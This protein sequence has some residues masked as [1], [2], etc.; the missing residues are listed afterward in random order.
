M[1]CMQN[2][3]EWRN[4]C[5]Q[6]EKDRRDRGETQ[7]KAW[8]C[9]GYLIIVM[10][11]VT[12]ISVSIFEGVDDKDLLRGV[13][14]PMSKLPSTVIDE[15]PFIYYENELTIWVENSASML[16]FIT[17]KKVSCPESFLRYMMDPVRLIES[18]IGDIEE[19][20]YHWFNPTLAYQ[21]VHK[22]TTTMNPEDVL[23]SNFYIDYN[24]QKPS[25]DRDQY[26]NSLISV[27]NLI[28]T[29]HLNLIITDFL[30]DERA[31]NND[32]LKNVCER[33][34]QN[35]Q[36]IEIIALDGLYGGILYDAGKADVQFAF[37]YAHRS[38][39]IEENGRLKIGSATQ[40]GP[41][42]NMHHHRARPIYFILVGRTEACKAAAE[43]IIRQYEKYC[44]LEYADDENQGQHVLFDDSEKG[45]LRK[46]K[47]IV[48]GESGV[49]GVLQSINDN[50]V[51]K[52]GVIN[53]DEYCESTIDKIDA[54]GNL[55]HKEGVD[56]Y[57]ITRHKN[58]TEQ[59]YTI[60]YVFEPFVENLE[61]QSNKFDLAAPIKVEHLVFERIEKLTGAENEI[62]L[63]GGGYRQYS[64]KPFS[65]GD[66]EIHAK[67]TKNNSRDVCVELT[68]DA[69]AI[70]DGYY[71][72]EI[73]VALERKSEDY[74]P[75]I[76]QSGFSSL[77]TGRSAAMTNYHST[78]D[79]L[80]QLLHIRKAY[81]N[82]LK[83]KV[84]VA[85]VVVELQIL[86]AY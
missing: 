29:T 84:M 24:K 64:L 28:D 4:K 55:C 6:N 72:I 51:S 77:N 59:Q 73:P 32:E 43:Q 54:K 10:L 78:S 71:R 8:C 17:N 26:G 61:K 31:L 63:L 22:V 41:R 38:D 27:L 33:I 67:V 9:L 23:E 19:V 34:F 45:V 35:N 1:I 5:M 49:G 70:P 11:I 47:E 2:T 13:E 74:L 12:A 50:N 42:K 37:N 20:N 57:K 60:Q 81:K 39:Y 46:A 7:K 15:S 53:Q 30:E 62:E 80:D 14:I 65:T 3:T 85:N 79:L 68:V 16:G 82:Y 75:S 86:S 36:A 66:R 48:F 58:V 44:K 56:A 76:S 69:A 21:E 52:H 25:S 83:K 18:W 40:I